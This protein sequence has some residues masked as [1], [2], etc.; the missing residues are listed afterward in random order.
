MSTYSSD[1]WGYDPALAWSDF[2]Y[3][4]VRYTDSAAAA[5]AMAC[6]VKTY[7]AAIGVDATA[8]PLRT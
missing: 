5:T 7:D 1:G 4:K 8:N 6:G 2:N 3:V